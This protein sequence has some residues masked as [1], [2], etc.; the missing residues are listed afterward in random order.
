MKFSTIR[1]MVV[2]GLAAACTTAAAQ[3]AAAT[4]DSRGG[5]SI[6]IDTHRMDLKRRDTVA[7]LYVRIQSSARKVCRDSTSSSYGSPL[8]SFDRCYKATVESAVRSVRAP[9]LTTLH[10]E[11][12]RAGSVAQARN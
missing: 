12:T 8:R 5:P 10:E 6:R 4:S 9:L 7:R 1:S 11:G 2:L 3:A